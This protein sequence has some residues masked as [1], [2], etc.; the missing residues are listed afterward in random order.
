MPERSTRKVTPVVE[1][2]KFSRSKLKTWAYNADAIAEMTSQCR[3]TVLRH[4][5][6][7]RFNPASLDSVSAYVEGRRKAFIAREQRKARKSV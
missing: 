2:K 3:A 6:A 5:A 4:I 1:I 7:E